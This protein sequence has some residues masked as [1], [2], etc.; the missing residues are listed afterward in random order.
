MSSRPKSPPN[1]H[2]TANSKSPTTNSTNF[3]NSSNDPKDMNNKSKHLKISTSS[4]SL[5]MKI[6]S[7]N[8]WNKCSESLTQKCKTKSKNTKN[9][10]HKLK[11]WH[12]KWPQG[13]RK[14]LS[15]S[16]T[17]PT[18]QLGKWVSSS[19]LHWTCTET[20]VQVL[21]SFT[22]SSVQTLKISRGTWVK[23]WRSWT[24]IRMC[25]SWKIC[26]ILYGV[27]SCDV[28]CGFTTC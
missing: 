25:R 1:S 14:C 11:I 21:A 10:G 16:R 26:G 27:R 17:P 3:L 8:C 28:V 7:W 24:A 19:S 13:S 2:K 9:P 4:F 23:G 18:I 22:K 15:T 5:H 12:R 6:S 20:W